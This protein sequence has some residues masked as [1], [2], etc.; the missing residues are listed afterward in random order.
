MSKI[1]WKKIDLS[2]AGPYATAEDQETADWN[3][4]TVARLRR[5][6][7]RED[8]EPATRT[9]VPETVDYVSDISNLYS[10]NLNDA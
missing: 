3:G 1:D 2:D 9:K 6:R 7:A 5:D 8:L 4:I 10:E